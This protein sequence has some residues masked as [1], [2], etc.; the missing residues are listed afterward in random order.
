MSSFTLSLDSDVLGEDD[1]LSLSQKS[2]LSQFQYDEETDLDYENEYEEENPSSEEFSSQDF[3]Q[4]KKPCEESFFGKEAIDDPKVICSLSLL[5]S[6]FDTCR[7]PNCGSAC[8]RSNTT[9]TFSGAMIT[10]TTTCN[11]NH[12]TKW[13][14]SP[15]VGTGKSKVA[16]INALLGTYSYLSGLNVK[17]MLEFLGRLR[18][19]CV[20]KSFIYKL[21]TKVLYHVIWAFWQYMQAREIHEVKKS[22]AE[23]GRSL[24]V[25][26]DGKFDSPGFSAF[27]CSYFVMDLLTKKVLGFWVATK[28]MATSSSMMEPLA[29]KEVL[30]DL[31]H[32]HDLRIDTVTTD[33]SSSMKTMMSELGLDLPDGYITPAHLFDIWHVIK[34]VNKDLFKASKLKSCLVLSAWQ[35]SI[36]NQMWH[37]FSSCQGSEVLLREKL[38]S[39]TSHMCNEHE[40][41]ENKE[42]KKCTHGNL[43]EDREKP[44]LDQDSLAVSKVKAAIKGYKNTRLEDLSMMT[45][46]THTGG[47]E[48]LFSLQGKYASKQIFFSQE[49]MLC[50][51]ALT[52]IDH[53][54]NCNRSQG[55]TRSGA[56]QFDLVTNRQGS[57]YYIKPKTAPKDMSWKDSIASVTLQAY[58][59]RAL[60]TSSLPLASYLKTRTKTAVRPDKDTAISK[61]Q[62]RM[63]MSK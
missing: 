10:I 59:L 27:Y 1:L 4:E 31:A 37:A 63:A 46:F 44:W 45:K 8:D 58:E 6:L 47:V 28:E 22:Q 43:D 39:I 57:K 7:Q 12:T 23:T 38:L 54:R 25:A 11:S 55:K 62:T 2:N 41:V 36:I 53:N 48:N 30:L 35:P 56:L 34:G 50:K 60:P 14:S 3:S 52:A 20:S 49:S 13:S 21:Q 26:A 61:H 16:T 32:G 17:K 9:W 5:L 29:A 18:I 42:Y 40:F 19:V 24:D 51:N 33:R 15:T